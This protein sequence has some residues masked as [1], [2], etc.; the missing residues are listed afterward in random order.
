VEEYAA[1][2]ARDPY[3]E[4]A[5]KPAEGLT[6]EER[7]FLP[8]AL[9]YSDP[10][11]MIYRYP[12][13]GE[14]FDRRNAQ[15]E[16]G[17]RNSSARR[18]S[19]SADVVATGVVRRGFQEH[20][21][22]VHEWIERTS[23]FTLADQ[24]RMGEKAARDCRKGAAR[25]RKA[26]RYGTHRDL[27][28]ALL[29]PDPAT[30]LRFQYR[31]HLASQRA[32]APRFRLPD[33]ARLQLSRARDYVQHRFG[34]APVGSGQARARSPT[35]PSRSLPEL[36]FEWS[37]TDSGVSIRTKQT[38]VPVTAVSSLRMAAARGTRYA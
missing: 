19:R 10:H 11:H 32:A 5:L 34:V 31:R 16:T 38:A 26:G 13:Y 6:E 36:G 25:I 15:V 24:R 8:E 22:E 33:D 29:S 12:R 28:H 17:A 37:A 9:F 7:A 30:A 27:D 3:L 1:G 23:H 18:I 2:A 4:M 35:K 14:L 21:P 20:D